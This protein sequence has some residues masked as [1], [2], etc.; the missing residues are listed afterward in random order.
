MLIQPELIISII[1]IILD[2]AHL[3][4]ITIHGHMGVVYWYSGHLLFAGNSA[5]TPS[6]QNKIPSKQQVARAG[7]NMC[8]QF[9]VVVCLFE[10]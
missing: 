2:C 5:L 6:C 9:E 3:Y 10:S 8:G 7:A 1:V 4:L